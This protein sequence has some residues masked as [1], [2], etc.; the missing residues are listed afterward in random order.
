MPQVLQNVVFPTE[1]DPDILPLYA[2]PE[3][4]ATI[5]EEPVRVTS[6]AHL[7]NVLDRRRATVPAGRRVSF[8]S[9]FNAFPASYWQHWTT[10]RSV[11]LTVRTAGRGTV[12]VYRSNGSGVK[13]RILTNEVD[14]AATTSVELVLNQYSDGGWIWFDLVADAEDL[15]AE[16]PRLELAEVDAV[17][18]HRA[19]V[20]LEPAADQLRERQRAARQRKLLDQPRHPPRRQERV[21]SDV[22]ELIAARD[23][24]LR[25]AKHLGPDLQDGCLGR[26]GRED[27][28]RA[29]VVLVECGYNVCTL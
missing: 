29:G 6:V 4:W 10:V 8:A 16:P 27:Q 15:A 12:L 25:R 19:A 20:G 18:R 3:T 17:E 23:L 28:G 11:M 1:R 7:A 9:Y 5:D 14:G 22:K 21:P 24:L 26:R 2:D 13:Q